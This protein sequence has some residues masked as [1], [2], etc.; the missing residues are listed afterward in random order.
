MS[1]S[2]NASSLLKARWRGAPLAQRSQRSLALQARPVQAFAQQGNA[3]INS[4]VSRRAVLLGLCSVVSAFSVNLLP[5]GQGG[6]AIAADSSPRQ[7]FGK[8]IKK[9]ENDPIET[10]VPSILLARKQMLTI[11]GILGDEEVSMTDIRQLLRGGPVSGIRADLKAVKEYA[12]TVSEESSVATGEAVNAAL[13]ALEKVDVLLLNGGRGSAQVSRSD[14]QGYVDTVVASID[15]ALLAVPPAVME[16]SQAFLDSMSSSTKSSD[17]ASG[18]STTS[19]SSSSDTA[20]A[21]TLIRESPSSIQE[22]LF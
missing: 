21:R 7:G 9:K 19:S 4:D 1:V 2:A 18:S 22:K 5:A 16:S 17:S 10:Y 11:R 8:Y 12:E 6:A 15:K 3:D 13:R 14:V 20:P